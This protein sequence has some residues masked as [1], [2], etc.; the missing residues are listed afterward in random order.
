[1]KILLVED[2]ILVQKSLGKMLQRRGH[3][4][5]LTANGKEAINLLS[6]EKYDRIICDLMLQDIT[7][8]DVIEEAK[9]YYTADEIESRFVII[10]AYSSDFVL[11]KALNYRCKV[12]NKPFDN[13]EETIQLLVG[14]P[15]EVK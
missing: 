10:T 4:V 12:I 2:E 3:L 1:M 8:F 6:K 13:L 15:C 14:T 5:S 7:G 9:R 11:K